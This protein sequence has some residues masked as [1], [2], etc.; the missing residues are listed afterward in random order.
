MR[1]PNS[2]YLSSQSS[3]SAAIKVSTVEVFG[4]TSAPK[5][6]ESR[7]PFLKNLNSF[8]KVTTELHVPYSST[9]P[10]EVFSRTV[11][12]VW[13]YFGCRVHLCGLVGC[14]G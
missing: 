6:K 5:K 14:G 4:R 7:E 1:R 11:A 2:D 9:L 12:K 8:R 10:D 13:F 3:I